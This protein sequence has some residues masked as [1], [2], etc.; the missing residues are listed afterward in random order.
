MNIVPDTS[1]QPTLHA[2]LQTY[3]VEQLALALLS[4]VVQQH[5]GPPLPVRLLEVG[6]RVKLTDDTPDLLDTPLSSATQPQPR[7]PLQF[8]V[9]VAGTVEF[10][11]SLP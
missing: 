3:T 1:P 7:G 11:F 10:T 2:T 4:R 8:M 5:C 9:L 6:V